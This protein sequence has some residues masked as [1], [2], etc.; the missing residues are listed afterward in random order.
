MGG[1]MRKRNKLDSM[2]NC[3]KGYKAVLEENGWSVVF[4]IV[5]FI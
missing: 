4:D 1:G 3:A 2:T 5:S